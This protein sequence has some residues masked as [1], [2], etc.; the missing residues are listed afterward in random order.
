MSLVK[1]NKMN[2]LGN[3]IIVV[4]MR[5][6][7]DRI[8]TAA[9]VAL[10]A[11][12]A[13]KFDQMMV[14]Y[15]PRTSG[16]FSFVEIINSDGSTAQACGNGMRC[17]AK[18]LAAEC[19]EKTYI[20]ETVA[21]VLKAAVLDDGLISVDMGAPQEV[22]AIETL[23]D[24]PLL[25]SPSFVSMGN[26]HA[27]FWVDNDV[28]SH[29]LDRFGPLFE[30]HPIFPNRANISIAHVSSNETIYMRTWERGAGLT[31][32]CGSAACAVAVAA[33]S[34]KR[35]GRR[36]SITVPSGGVLRIEWRD[37][38]DHVIMIGPAEFEFQGKLDPTD[39][40]EANCQTR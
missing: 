7:I 13:T 8:S 22:R 5:H 39:R 37:E 19:D 18:L 27:I 15:P 10:A 36:V 9:V 29:E 16:T 6:R 34:T 2:G 40:R 31:L 17:V 28:W 24:D 38:D 30:H 21:G 1:F 11:E 14:L 33:A 35:T 4:D 26:P 12:P 23:I 25:H 32:A 3:T 20:L